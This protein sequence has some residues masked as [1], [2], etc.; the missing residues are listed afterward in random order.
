MPPVLGCIA[1]DFTGA[2]DIASTLSV[3]GLRT[4]LHLGVPDS[5]RFPDSDAIVVA[6]KT[7]TIPASKA[8]HQSVKAQRRLKEAGVVQIY[9]KYCS[10]FDSTDEG[11]IGPVLEALMDTMGERF[12]VACPAFPANGRTVYRGHLFVDDVL[13]SESGMRHHP[14]TPMTDSN[15]VRVLSRQMTGKVGL[16][17]YEIVRQGASAIQDRL[18]ELRRASYRCA[19]VDAL[20]DQHL[21][22]VATACSEL[23][24]LTG[25]SAMAKGLQEVYRRKQLIP[26]TQRSDDQFAVPPGHAAIIAGSCSSAT[27]AQV[28]RMANKS[29]SFYVNPLLLETDDVVGNAAAW[30]RTRMKDGPILIYS[31]DSPEN[32]A[33]TQQ[34]LGRT[35]G[36]EMV[37]QALAEIAAALVDGG[38]SRL[39]VAGGE[40]SGAVLTR[41]KIRTL[42]IGPEIAPGVPWTLTHD[43]G[44]PLTLALK[45]GNFGDEN[46]FHHAFQML[47]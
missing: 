26:D 8:V 14:L 3:S 9:F 16:V 35:R 27:R 29:N 43:K 10:T 17:P 18:E 41:L 36:G 2:A 34:R 40:T 13:L 20:H 1:D 15:L 7:R 33:I 39:I 28:R 42:K 45:S 32:V 12:T 31:T 44:A 4:I 11:N 5:G 19:V 38:V 6:L 47:Q 30:A 24:L 21:R 46:F 22:Y 37:E 23:P 25:G